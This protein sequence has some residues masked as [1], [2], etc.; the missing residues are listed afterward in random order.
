MKVG[1]EGLILRSV[2]IY[3]SELLYGDVR[4]FFALYLLSAGQSAV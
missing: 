4:S 3:V 2:L 1:I